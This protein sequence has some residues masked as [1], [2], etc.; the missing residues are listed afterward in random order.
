MFSISLCVAVAVA[1]WN[2]SSNEWKEPFIQHVATAAVLT[3][4]PSPLSMLQ[5][6]STEMQAWYEEGQEGSVQGQI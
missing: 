4:L 6:V 1:V 5:K 3:I 2:F